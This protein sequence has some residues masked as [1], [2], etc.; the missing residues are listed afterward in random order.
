[1][2]LSGL[3]F[4]RAVWKAYHVCRERMPTAMV[5]TAAAKARTYDRLTLEIAQRALANGDNSIDVGA[6]Y[7]SILETLVKLSP[8]GSHWAFEPI[9]SLAKQLRKSFPTVIV[10]ELALSD[11]TGS[12]EFNFLPGVPAYS[13]LL[14]RPEVEAGERVRKLRVDV[15][16]LDDCI[17]EKVP[18]SFIKIDVE[19]SEAEVLR[20]A[21]DI[22]QRH[23]PVV[24]FECAAAKL[25]DCA[26]ALENAGLN[27]SFLPDYLAGRRRALDEVM[28]IGQERGEYYFVASRA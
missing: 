7:G 26:P 25:D 28:R 4:E 15:R 21:A 18:I 5:S 11:Y 27:V 22:L 17:P 12:T 10:Q 2:L 23:K 13:S 8:A 16:R 19:G 9:P 14:T 1:M 20:G 6:H 24:V 3:P